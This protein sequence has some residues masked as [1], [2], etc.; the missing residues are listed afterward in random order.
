MNL[1]SYILNHKSVWFILILAL[2]LRLPLLNGSFWLDEAAQA[3][4]STRP[5]SQQLQIQGDFQPPLFHLFVHFLS[6]ISH[7]ERWLRLASI[8]PGL[9][10]I[11][12]I[13]KIGC[14]LSGPSIGWFAALLLATSQLHVFYSQ[15]LRPYSMATM[16]AVLSMYYFHKFIQTQKGTWHLVLCTTL[17]MYSIYTFPFLIL[18]QIIY[19]LI[20]KRH[21]L[22]LCTWHLAL[23]ALF[24]FPWLPSFWAQFQTGMGV[25]RDLP[26]WK[27]AVSPPPI[28]ALLL[29][30][31]K[32]VFG[33]LDLPNSDLPLVILSGLL[34][35]VLV[36]ALS[37]HRQKYFKLLCLWLILPVLAGFLI[38]FKVPLLEPKRFLFCLPALYLLL[39]MVKTRLKYILVLINCLTVII[40]WAVPQFQREPWKQAVGEVEAQITPTTTLVFPWVNPYAPWVWYAHSMSKTI[41]FSESQVNAQVVSQ[42]LDLITQTEKLI[43]FDYLESIT[44]PNKLIRNQL[45]SRGWSQVNAVIYPGIGQIRYYSRSPLYALQ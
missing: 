25:T 44:D 1:K 5:L 23:V 3:L 30:A 20:Y 29:V 16:F 17:G 19:L 13:Y 8:V 35:F 11:Y 9:I 40:Y 33:R 37:A 27:T 14:R 41:A 26:L 18:A 32:F 24:C 7:S 45:T 12:F 43:Y 4:E 34:I 21:L 28:K 15:E 31:P 39:A 38:S 6:L 10:T 2:L 42:N 36:L 22:K